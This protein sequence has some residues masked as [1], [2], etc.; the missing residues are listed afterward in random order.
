MTEES[1]SATQDPT[2]ITPDVPED[3]VTP[4][5][6]APAPPAIETQVV[7]EQAAPQAQAPGPSKP[8]EPDAIQPFTDKTHETLQREV[9]SIE[10]GKF[11]RA[12][13]KTFLVGGSRAANTRSMDRE[14]LMARRGGVHRLSHRLQ[15]GVA[16]MRTRQT[17]LAVEDE[18]RHTRDP[19]FTRSVVIADGLAVQG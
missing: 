19:H 14:R 9:A 11:L 5:A 7:A 10:P 6:P 16:L 17:D 3:I 18:K 15:Q 4:I 13:I 2:S 12:H 8:A 1:T